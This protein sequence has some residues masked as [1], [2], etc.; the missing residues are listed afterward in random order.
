MNEAGSPAS[1]AGAVARAVQAACCT[2]IHLA[3]GAEAAGFAARL[4]SAFGNEAWCRNDA[5][6]A[7]AQAAKM[8]RATSRSFVVVSAAELGMGVD[9]LLATTGPDIAGGMAIAVVDGL[10]GEDFSGLADS[11]RLARVAHLPLLE[12]ADSEEAAAM[13]GRAFALSEE[14]CCPV[15][16]RLTPSLDS[17][18]AQDGAPAGESV[19]ATPRPDLSVGDQ[20][21]GERNQFL[22]A[23]ERELANFS[24]GCELNVLFRGSDRSVGFVTSGAVYQLVKVAFPES[25]MVKMGLS[26]PLPMKHLRGL[27]EMCREVLVVEEGAAIVAAE[28]R[29]EGL[30][31]HG[32]NIL[33]SEYP[34]PLE[35]LRAGVAGLRRPPGR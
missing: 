27:S 11:R 4:G 28:L 1:T 30:R 9:R 35:A 20:A 18:N 33:A 21:G 29:A 17:G 12:P 16:L 31:I 8:A 15:L 2:A 10:P 6:A 3:A 5:D 26:H 19:T 13:T 14:F 32:H 34:L 7:L 24:N 25:P 23:R 22:I